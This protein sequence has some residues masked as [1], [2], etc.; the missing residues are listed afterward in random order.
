M[1]QNAPQ[2][3]QNLK[4][5]WRSMCP[6]PLRRPQV[7]QE[8]GLSPL[9]ISLVP[10]LLIHAI[11]DNCHMFRNP[12]RATS[13]SSWAPDIIFEHAIMIFHFQIMRGLLFTYMHTYQCSF[14][15]Q[16][17]NCKH[18]WTNQHHQCKCCFLGTP[19]L[20]SH[21]CQCYSSSHCSQQG[22]D[23]C[24]QQQDPEL[25]YMMKTRK[26]RIWVTSW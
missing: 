2:S 6:V 7:A 24:S 25:V 23:K 18:M 22:T 13:G 11:A 14:L 5:F 15:P 17:H 1:P 9:T 4:I 16:N 20:H 10:T 26:L 12:C 3:T 8:L 19:L 21:Q